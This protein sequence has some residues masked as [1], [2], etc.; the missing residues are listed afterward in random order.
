MVLFSGTPLSA[1]G[2]PKLLYTVMLFYSVEYLHILLS[3][4]T[5]TF[6]RLAF[7]S[8]THFCFWLKQFFTEQ[9]FLH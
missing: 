5:A 6:K 9:L 7:N 2:V 3:S 8:Q 1:M 4:F